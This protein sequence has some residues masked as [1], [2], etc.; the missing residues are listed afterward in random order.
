MPSLRLLSV[1]LRRH[2][3]RGIPATLAPERCGD[4]MVDGPAV[5]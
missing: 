2:S 1:C 3:E 5:G 4:N